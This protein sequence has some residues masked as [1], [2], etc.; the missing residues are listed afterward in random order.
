MRVDLSHSRSVLPAFVLG[1]LLIA[2]PILG[3]QPTDNTRA[4]DATGPTPAPVAYAARPVLL[5][6]SERR[7]PEES[8]K[9]LFAA[10]EKDLPEVDGLV[11]ASD[12]HPIFMRGGHGADAGPVS[13]PITVYLLGDCLPPPTQRPFPF[14]AR[15]GWVS[16]VDGHIVPVIHVQCSEIGAEISG[17]TEWMK[18][19]KRTAAMGEAMARVI[20]HEWVHVAAQTAAH[21]ADGVTKP[22]F[23]VND[24]LCGEQAQNCPRQRIPNGSAER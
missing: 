22:V 4:G 15:L 8:W 24:L 6:S 18:Q 3:G 5:I 1:V 21:G 17:R 14:V 10:L 12:A 9:A 11:P 20:L 7:M 19:D 2:A 13:R 16:Q 23:S